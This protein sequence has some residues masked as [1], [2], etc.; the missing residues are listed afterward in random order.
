MGGIVAERGPKMRTT[1]TLYYVFVI[2]FAFAAIMLN[3][4]TCRTRTVYSNTWVVQVEG[5]LTGAERIAAEKDLILL[6][7]VREQSLVILHRVGIAVAICGF[8]YRKGIQLIDRPMRF[9]RV[10]LP[11]L[12]RETFTFC[13]CR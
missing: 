7:Q 9:A 3:L 5:G 13:L 10:C 1:S 4:A 8:E 6:G 11:T 2:L 12:K